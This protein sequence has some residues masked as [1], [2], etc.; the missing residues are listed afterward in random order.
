MATRT[1]RASMP[2]LHLPRLLTIPR[3]PWLLAALLVTALGCGGGGDTAPDV[4][5]TIMPTIAS[6]KAGETVR[7]TATVSGSTN[8]K[9]NWSASGGGVTSDGVFTAPAL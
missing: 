8:T 5:V 9:I 4:V 1:W 6:V 3:A 7:F 2:R